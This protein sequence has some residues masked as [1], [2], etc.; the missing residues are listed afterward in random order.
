MASIATPT[1][2]K[3]ERL[4]ITHNMPKIAVST[5]RK[6]ASVIL[7][8]LFME[9]SSPF[10]RSYTENSG[11]LLHDMSPLETPPFYQSIT[12]NFEKSNE[13]LCN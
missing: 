5:N 7:W 12:N 8:V 9:R 13:T 4:K 11:V 1:Q 2:K 3:V 10:W 6:N